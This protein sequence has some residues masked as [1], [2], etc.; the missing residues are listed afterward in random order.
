MSAPYTTCHGV[1]PHKCKFS[2]CHIQLLSHS[3]RSTARP[4]AIP[5]LQTAVLR[6]QVQPLQLQ[7]LQAAPLLLLLPRRHLQLRLGGRAALLQL[8]HLVQ[9]VLAAM[10]HL[11]W[12]Q[13][14]YR[15]LC[16]PEAA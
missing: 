5:H 13:H 15:F 8:L 1:Q 6:I 9:Q 11:Q 7:L 14:M 16:K 10:Q 4:H 2:S 3:K 12:S